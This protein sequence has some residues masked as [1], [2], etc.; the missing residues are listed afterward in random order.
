[1]SAAL[2]TGAIISTLAVASINQMRVVFVDH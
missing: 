1:M 2:G